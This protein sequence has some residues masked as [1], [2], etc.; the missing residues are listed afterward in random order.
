[1]LPEY[2][3]VVYVTLNAVNETA[4]KMWTSTCFYSVGKAEGAIYNPQIHTRELKLKAVPLMQL[5][6]TE[7]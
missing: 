3:A 1:M 4:I 6:W 2:A 7:Q 5:S